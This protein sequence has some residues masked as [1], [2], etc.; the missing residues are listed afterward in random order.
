[1]K[2]KSKGCIS[3]P[4]YSYI[5]TLEYCRAVK[6]NDNMNKRHNI[7]EGKKAKEN[8]LEVYRQKNGG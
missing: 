1:L 5:F 8:M 6:I 4:P 2:G 7:G 3:C